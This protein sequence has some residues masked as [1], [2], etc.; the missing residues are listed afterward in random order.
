MELEVK[1]A[2]RAASLSFGV[3]DILRKTRKREYVYARHAM[4]YYL[5]RVMRLSQHASARVIEKDHATIIHS[6]RTHE[7][8]MKFDKGYQEMYNAF[9]G[10]MKQFPTKRW[11]CKECV[12][13]SNVKK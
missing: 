9:I 8:L 3:I 11:L 13:P 12:F 2:L 10:Q 1:Q 7:D 6:C 5:H 4:A